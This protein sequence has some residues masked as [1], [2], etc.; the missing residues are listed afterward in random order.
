M[1]IR[2]CSICSIVS[3]AYV[4]SPRIMRQNRYICM[5]T[6]LK[7]ACTSHPCLNTLFKIIWKTVQQ[8]N[9][10]VTSKHSIH[11]HFNHSTKKGAPLYV[12]TCIHLQITKTFNLQRLSML[13]EWRHIPRF[14][15]DKL[16]MVLRVTICR[17]SLMS[18]T[19]CRNTPGRH[20]RVSGTEDALN[21][22]TSRWQ[23]PMF[24]TGGSPRISKIQY[25]RS[26]KYLQVILH[27]ADYRARRSRC[28]H[29]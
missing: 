12:L 15:R 4:Q 28:M 29:A 21:I 13:S 11:P 22:W 5:V 26:E 27:W 1:F 8:T 2:K 16:A 6:K 18:H 25:M 14:Y 3:I 9:L 10:D 17:H 23:R 7:R 19:V 24:T 20:M